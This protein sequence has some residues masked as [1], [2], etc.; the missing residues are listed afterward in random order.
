MTENTLLYRHINPGW[1]REGRITSQAFKPFPKDDGL[2]SVYDGD[3]INPKGSYEHFTQTL[4]FKSIGVKAVS[5]SE[6]KAQELPTRPD[7][8]AF[9]EHAVIDFKGL[10][11]S[12]IANK[13]KLLTSNAISRGWLYQEE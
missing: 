13:S 10:A 12:Q 1:I 5:V 2:L 9:A 8:G 11:S 3:L 4:G 7:P 6:C